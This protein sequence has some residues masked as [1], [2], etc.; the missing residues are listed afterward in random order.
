MMG[1]KDIDEWQVEIKKKG[2][3]PYGID[4]LVLYIA[5]R[6]KVDIAKLKIELKKVIRENIEV[7]PD[8]IIMDKARLLD[9][10]GM[11]TELKEKRTI[12]YR[13]KK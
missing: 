2:N 9:R 10:L 13:P 6:K 11:E 3:D 5:P 4:E 1:H 7:A 8:I 12:D